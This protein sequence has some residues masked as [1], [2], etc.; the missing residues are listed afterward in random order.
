MKSLI[1]LPAMLLG[2]SASP[3]PHDGLRAAHQ[4]EEDKN[5]LRE[6][7]EWYRTKDLKYSGHARL[8]QGDLLD[9]F[10]PVGDLTDQVDVDL[11][12]EQ[13]S[14]QQEMEEAAEQAAWTGLAP[15]FGRNLVSVLFTDL[16][17]IFAAPSGPNLLAL[18]VDSLFFVIFP[19][20]GGIMNMSVLY[21]YELDPVTF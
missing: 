18:L 6:M 11:G 9:D 17:N 8:T 3:M 21:N 7:D 20:I 5:L 1:L 2:C 14:E 10:D 4:K 12:Q 19:L 15:L 13:D 16:I